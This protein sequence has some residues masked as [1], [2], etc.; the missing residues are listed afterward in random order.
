MPKEAVAEGVLSQAERTAG[1]S[2][3]GWGQGAELS[4]PT[5]TPVTQPIFSS[6]SPPSGCLCQAPDLYSRQPGA[7]SPTGRETGPFP[8]LSSRSRGWGHQAGEQTLTWEARLE[9][10]TLR[11]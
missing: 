8:R 10:E 2:W 5:G 3:Q 1:R 4:A 9:A 7:P 6:L 11:A